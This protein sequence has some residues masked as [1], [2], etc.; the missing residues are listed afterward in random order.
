M[1]YFRLFLFLIIGCFISLNAIS[2]VKFKKSYYYT[3][4]DTVSYHKIAHQTFI[5][6]VKEY[7]TPA[8]HNRGVYWFR[9]DILGHQ[10]LK[11]DLIINISNPNLDTVVLFQK[12]NGQLVPKDTSGNNFKLRDST[13]LRYS[14]FRVAANTSS[15]WLKTKLKKEMVFPVSIQ[16]VQRFNRSEH[17][18]FFWLGL[19]YGF[20][21]M[22]LAINITLYFSFKDFKFIYYSLFLALIALT[23]AYSDGLFV[24]L[25]R[26]K[27]WL[28]YADLPVH[29]A[30]A[31]AG[32]IFATN[33]LELNSYYRRLSWVGVSLALIMLG[34]Y[35]GHLIFGGAV[36]FFAGNIAG[37]LLLSLYWI[38]G[39]TRFKIDVFARFFVFAYGLLLIFALDFF[40]FR[41]LGWKFLNLSPNELKLASVMEMVVL[42]VAIIYRVKKLHQ[43]HQYYRNEI[44][45]YI[46][47]DQALREETELNPSSSLAVQPDDL[48]NRFG[49]SERE[50]EV[51]N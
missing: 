30:V 47:A 3:P 37:L 18:N 14:R 4:V 43:E 45:Q 17:L 2:Q 27:M 42:S 13:Y 23:F 15:V 26:N 49:L 36:V 10:I 35:A 31:I 20:V 41:T 40:F 28:N 21:M 38:A 32:A 24:L 34:C 29:L 50:T 48:K 22:V 8:F 33:F 7:E 44:Q 12:V 9:L 19:Y 39:L 16:A 51:L 6:L 25:S 46:Q 1:N 11:K 5:P